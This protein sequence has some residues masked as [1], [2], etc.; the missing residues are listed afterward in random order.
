MI[1]PDVLYKA[2]FSQTRSA[3]IILS[4]QGIPVLWNEAFDELFVEL[5][6]F[7]PDKLSVPLFD[8][9]QERDSFQYS[10]YITE[11]LLGHMGAASMETSLRSVSGGRLWLRTAMSLIRTEDHN[12]P[13]EEAARWIWCSFQNISDQ[14]QRERELVSAKEEAEKATNR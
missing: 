7:A 14:K 8:W 11:V 6:G 1:L 10:Y 12:R 9:M 4:D 13:S 3:M 5:A 2:A